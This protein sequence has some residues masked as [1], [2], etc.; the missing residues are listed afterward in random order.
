MTESVHDEAEPFKDTWPAFQTDV[1]VHKININTE[2]LR[3]G[4]PKPTIYR[5]HETI[6]ILA[7]LIDHLRKAVDE[8]Q[9]KG[10]ALDEVMRLAQ[11]NEDLRRRL[12]RAER[13]G[14]NLLKQWRRSR[15]MRQQASVRLQKIEHL[16][17][18][19]LCFTNDLPQMEMLI[20]R[21]LR[22]AQGKDEA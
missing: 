3:I 18:S 5:E 11:E 8:R 21:A 4:Y 22:S 1:D 2:Y 13:R 6:H 12:E 9:A 20:R 15:E 17:N 10:T 19:A 16:L 14:D 7:N